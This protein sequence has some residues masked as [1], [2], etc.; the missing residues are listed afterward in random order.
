MMYY[1][2]SSASHHLFPIRNQTVTYSVEQRNSL[3]ET[4]AAVLKEL[5]ALQEASQ[6]PFNILL[7]LSPIG[8]TLVQVPP[9]AS[10]SGL[11]SLS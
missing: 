11:L 4:L 6:A 7:T 1:S 3:A 8:F 5:K 9:C 10:L 2:N